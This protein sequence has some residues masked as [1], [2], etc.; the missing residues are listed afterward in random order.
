MALYDYTKDGNN[1]GAQVR[2]SQT[3]TQGRRFSAESILDEIAYYVN[4]MI[5]NNAPGDF[6]I[7]QLQNLEREGKIQIVGHGT[8]RKVLKINADM[9]NVLNRIGFLD[10][11]CPVVVKVPFNI[12]SGRMD[13]IREAFAW[14]YMQKQRSFMI[15]NTQDQKEASDLADWIPEGRIY[16]IPTGFILIHE[17][18]TPIEMSSIVRDE[19]D[20]KGL[21]FTPQNVAST[22]AKLYEENDVVKAQMKRLLY[23]LDKYFI[24]KDINPLYSL[25]NFG[26]RQYSNGKEFIVPL[27]L[28]YA[29]PRINNNLSPHCPY[30]DEVLSHVAY[31][32]EFV[33]SDEARKNRTFE[34]L[35][36]GGLYSCKNLNCTANGSVGDRDPFMMS[37]AEVFATYLQ[38]MRNRIQTGELNLLPEIAEV[39]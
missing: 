9:R 12:Y 25:F 39:F 13:N 37:D 28:G 32:E 34:R 35:H 11:S 17:E 5:D 4:Y 7:M 8:N 29:L 27:D 2:A 33:L 6:L 3:Q 21:R 24:M 36:M 22:V 26:I 10:A 15:T 38:E 19:L 31:C 1:G 14:Y 18:V 20:A 30:C 23:L 16:D